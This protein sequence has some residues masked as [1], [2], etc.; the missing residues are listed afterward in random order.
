MVDFLVIGPYNAITYNDKSPSRKYLLYNKPE[1]I[2]LWIVAENGNLEQII[3]L[4]ELLLYQYL[5]LDPPTNSRIIDVGG[6][7]LS[8]TGIK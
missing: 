4:S 2:A 8:L 6:I 5:K 1:Q 7:S 3:L